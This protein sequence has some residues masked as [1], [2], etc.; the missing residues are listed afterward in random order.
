MPPFVLDTTP[1]EILDYDVEV[2]P[3][4]KAARV[5]WTTD[6]PGTSQVEYGPTSFYD[7]MVSDGTLKMNH[8]LTLQSLVPETLYH[9]QITSVDQFGNP[10]STNDLTFSTRA[11][12]G[13]M[14]D[15]FALCGGLNE[16]VWE[17][18]DPLQDSSY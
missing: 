13:I 15:D 12:T 18:V 17:W 11:S 9:F 1:I 16:A 10:I 4:G 7:Q 8:V 6:V 2:F 14:S 3:D 5:I